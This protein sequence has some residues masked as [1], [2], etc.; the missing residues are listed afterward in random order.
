MYLLNFCGLLLFSVLANAQLSSTGVS[1]ST[2]I[3]TI[4]KPSINSKPINQVS[5]TQSNQETNCIPDKSS[6][7][8]TLSGG[9]VLNRCSIS[10]TNDSQLF[11]RKDFKSQPKSVQYRYADEVSFL[12]II[13]RFSLLA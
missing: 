9:R 10:P 3:G 7:N 8:V 2:H 11:S 5:S 6:L 1:A 12:I 13:K 4:Q